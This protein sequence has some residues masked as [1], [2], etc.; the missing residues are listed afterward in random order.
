M[1]QVAVIVVMFVIVVIVIV[2]RS[3][4]GKAAI[5]AVVTGLDLEC[6]V[7]DTEA[8]FQ[9]SGSRSQERVIQRRAYGLRDEEYLALKILTTGLPEL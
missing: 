4:A 8:R 5:R 7:A 9:R 3:V 6:R 1:G 2:A